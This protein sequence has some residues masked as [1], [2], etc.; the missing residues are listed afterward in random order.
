M[1]DHYY[2]I[3]DK[4]YGYYHKGKLN[5]IV[6]DALY[7]AIKDNVRLN[8]PVEELII[9]DAIHKKSVAAEAA[10]HPVADLGCCGLNGN[11]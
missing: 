9:G 8:I 10:T 3:K 4:V 1:A 11:N 2:N 7:N 5:Y 6:A